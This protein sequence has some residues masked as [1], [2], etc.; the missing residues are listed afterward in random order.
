MPVCVNVG[1]VRLDRWVLWDRFGRNVLY[2][3]GL[4]CD[5]LSVICNVVERLVLLIRVVGTLPW[6]SR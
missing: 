6:L 4:S 3:V 5:K 2:W 1:Y